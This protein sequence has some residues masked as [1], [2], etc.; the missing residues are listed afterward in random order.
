ML[1][2][3]HP[4]R[5]RQRLA[6]SSPAGSPSPAPPPPPRTATRHPPPANAHTTHTHR[7][8]GRTKYIF[9]ATY[10]H[11]HPPAA[12]SPVRARA[13]LPRATIRCRLPFGLLGLSGPILIAVGE[14]GTIGDETA[15][16]GASFLKRSRSTSYPDS[17]LMTTCF[18]VKELTFEFKRERPPPGAVDDAGVDGRGDAG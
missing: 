5:P 17:D 18:D 2:E 3:I 7:G 11:A 8:L 10:V 12:R 13:R 9:I 6:K 1:S 15:L 14:L 16:A 4:S